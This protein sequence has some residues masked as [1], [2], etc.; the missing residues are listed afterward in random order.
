MLCTLLTKCL[1]NWKYLEITG[2]NWKY[3]EITCVV[4]LQ[5]DDAVTECV[6][7]TSGTMVVKNSFNTGRSNSRLGDVSMSFLELVARSSQYSTTGANKGRGMCYPVCGMVELFP[8]PASAPRLVQTRA[9]VCV[10]LYVGWLSYFP[11]QPVLHDWCKQR[12]WYVLSCM[13][14]GSVI[15]RSSQC[16]TTGVNKG[17]GMCYPV[18]GM[19]HIKEPLLLM[20]KSSPCGGSGFPYLAI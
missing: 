14:D 20:G 13:W 19:M 16:S 10:I 17:R 15:S 9:V 4:C 7:V 8:V 5:G 12:P 1:T 2:N 3:L 6:V 18:C 11:F